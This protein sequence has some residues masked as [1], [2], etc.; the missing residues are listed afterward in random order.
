MS[1]RNGQYKIT[2]LVGNPIGRHPI[3]DKSGRPK[4]VLALPKNF[5]EPRVVGVACARYASRLPFS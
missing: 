3:E 5:R 1:L 2:S 4:R